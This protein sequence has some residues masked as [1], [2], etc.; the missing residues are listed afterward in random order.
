MAFAVLCLLRLTASW[1]VRFLSLAGF[2]MEFFP[3]NR[4]FLA[5]QAEGVAAEAVHMAVGIGIYPGRHTMVTDAG[6]GERGP[7]VT[8][9]FAVRM[10]VRGF[11]FTA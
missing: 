11:Q 7:E 10:L 3:R 4:W 1:S 5:D 9:I 6:F 2:S 8:V